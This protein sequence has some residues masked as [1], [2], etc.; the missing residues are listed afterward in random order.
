MSFK[1]NSAPVTLFEGTDERSKLVA[2]GRILMKEANG[3]AVKAFNQGSEFTGELDT[4]KYARLNQGTKEA[5]LL[6]CAKKGAAFEGR[7]AP[8]TYEEFARH[9]RDYY[10][11]QAFIRALSG[12][13]TDIVRPMLPYVTSNALGRLAQMINV[14]LGQTHEIV[15][16]SNDFFVWQDSSWGASRSV[17]ENTLY[18]ATIT[19]N[20]R[21]IS[22]EATAK[23]YQLVANDADFGL[24][25]NALT[26]GLYNK[27]TALWYG[28]LRAAATNTYYTPSYLT[29]SG[30]T[31]ANLSNIVEAVMAANN[32]DASQLMIF[33]RRP[34]LSVMLPT[35]TKQDAALT[36]G[37]GLEWMRNG[38]LGTVQGV[39]TFEM[40][41]A[42]L[43]GQVNTAGNMIMQDTDAYIIARAGAGYAPIYIGI[44]DGTPITLEL[45]PHETADMTLNVNMT[46]SIDVKPVFASKIGVI[47]NVI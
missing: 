6:F 40:R 29:A 36:Y 24:W 25:L 3:R 5:V 12:I 33:G 26:A 17:P 43:P 35:G 31:S 28:A 27:I 9:S 23:W 10:K 15:V 20:P 11:N 21:P 42:M 30:F 46:A 47:T 7:E 45:E 22:C 38:F 39:P 41:N 14:P 4:E 44:E 1:M 37:L 16:E 13:V 8:E 32:V 19:L 34:V 18:P 2:C